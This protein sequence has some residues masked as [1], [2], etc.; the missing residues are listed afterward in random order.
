MRDVAGIL[1]NYFPRI[2]YF[3]TTRFVL[4]IVICSRNQQ[5]GVSKGPECNFLHWYHTLNHS[6]VCSWKEETAQFTLMR[7][8]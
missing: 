5:N 8:G 4:I 2:C 7:A 6:L 3:L 1:V